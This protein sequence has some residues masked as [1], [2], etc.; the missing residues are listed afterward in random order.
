MN[1]T[2]ESANG[3]RT[4]QVF[5]LDDGPDQ[6]PAEDVEFEVHCRVGENLSRRFPIKPFKTRNGAIRYAHKFLNAGN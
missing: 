6:A 2:Y 1:L 4:A 5:R 3:N